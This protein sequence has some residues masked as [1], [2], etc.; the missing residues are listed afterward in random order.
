MSEESVI[1]GQNAPVTRPQLA[2]DLR[3]LGL[4]AGDEI[5]VHSSL[6]RLGWVVGGAQAVVLALLDVLTEEG[7]LMV[8]TPSA[9]NSD[10]S[11]WQR[12]FS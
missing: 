11:R 2:N 12:L 5:L 10:P 7:T 1:N 6:S 4:Q 3:T 9:N 8:P